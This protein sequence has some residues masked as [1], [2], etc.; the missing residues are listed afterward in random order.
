MK[1]RTFLQSLSPLLLPFTGGLP[2]LRAEGGPAPQRLIFMFSP[3]GIVPPNFWPDAPAEGDAFQLK[4]IL[5]PLAGF[6]D[7]LLM[8]Q[9]ISNKI[10]GDGDGHQRGMS[11][12]LTGIELF[13]G[14]I[15]GGGG[16]PAGWARGPSIDQVI[17]TRLQANPKTKTRFGSLELGVCVA[18]RADPWTRWVYA[19]ANKPVAPVSDPYQLL[20]R[21]Y[22]QMKDREHLK[23]VLDDVGGD[24]KQLSAHLPAADRALLEEHATLVRAMEKELQEDVAARQFRHAP[25]K[26]EDNV[27]LD[28][29]QMPKLSRM[30]I[31]LLVNAMANDMTRVASLQFTSS[32]GGAKMR[33][34]GI[35]EGHHDLSHDPD[36]NTGSQEKLTKINTWFCQQLAYLAER[37]DAIPEPGHTGSMLDH[38]LIVWT[39]E[40]GKGNSHALDDVPFVCLGKAPGVRS[41]RHV[42]F[43]KAAH[44]RLLLTFARTM[45][46]NLTTHGNPAMCEG[47]ALDL[48]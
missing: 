36:M 12:L 1:R 15:M 19:D 20:T 29:D 18:D 24:L 4:P 39:N 47:G 16:Q 30:Q 27:A 2:S 48:G 7:R 13:A 5:Q 38:T 21:L 42:R 6:K 25:P 8:V 22:G 3:N 26:L 40:L 43:D 14:N 37:L 9:G 23:S 33:W 31:D 46:V 45:G 41:N 28:N 35:Q 10:R 44:N 11:C 17:K 34:L 32:V